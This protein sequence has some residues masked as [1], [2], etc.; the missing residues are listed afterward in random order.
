MGN[1][2]CELLGI[3]KPVISAAMT[4]ITDAAFVA[5][6]SEAGGAGILGFNAGYTEMTPDPVETAERLRTQIKKVRELTS[7]PFGVNIM[8]GS[9]ID[10]FTEATLKILKEERPSF[11]LVLPMGPMNADVITDLKEWGIHIVVRPISPTVDNMKEAEA[12]G[13]D[14]LICTGFEAGGHTSDYNISL[15]SIF[16]TMRKE[17]SIPLMAAGGICDLQA[18]KAVAAMGADGV[19]AGTRFIVTDENPTSMLAKQAIIDTKAEDLIQ[20]PSNPGSIRVTRNETGLEMEKMFKE[21]ASGQEINQFYMGKGGF[22]SGM[23]LGDKDNGIVNCSQAIN[24]ITSIKSCK[25]V[26]DELGAAF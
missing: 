5:A 18:A 14:I 21:G 10:P 22:L 4:W 23:L 3:E 13:A 26:V 11:V 9:A 1:R 20:V 15:M 6:V 12:A 16:P 2:V 24:N 17:I 8:L 19:Y 25:E 7:K